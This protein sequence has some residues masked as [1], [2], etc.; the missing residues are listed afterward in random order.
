MGRGEE[1]L[2]DTA[3]KAGLRNSLRHCTHR[4]SDPAAWVWTLA[5]MSMPIPQCGHEIFVDFT[6]NQM[7]SQQTGLRTNAKAVPA[8]WPLPA[9]KEPIIAAIPVKIDAEEAH[10][11]YFPYGGRESCELADMEFRISFLCGWTSLSNIPQAAEPRSLSLQGYMPRKT[12]QLPEAVNVMAID[13][14]S[15]PPRL[16]QNR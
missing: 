2:T 16:M 7:A 14:P 11:A 6:Q 4:Q 13:A 5:V 1:M 15:I 10:E 12:I 9:A 8:T 3:P